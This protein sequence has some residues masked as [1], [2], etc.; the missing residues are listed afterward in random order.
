LTGVC[1][2]DVKSA[3]GIGVAKVECELLDEDWMDD[4]LTE[5]AVR[6]DLLHPKPHHEVSHGILVDRVAV[7]K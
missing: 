6:E 2:R 1:W 7:L 3:V 5:Q 4:V